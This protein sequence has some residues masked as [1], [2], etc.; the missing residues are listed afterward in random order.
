MEC[1]KCEGEMQQ[2]FIPDLAHYR[3]PELPVWYPGTF[4]RSFWGGIAGKTRQ[5]LYVQT[6]RC[7]DCG[8]L[9]AYAP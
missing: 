5:R 6:W 4:K 1:P 9:E 2:G 3:N 7:A 8:Y